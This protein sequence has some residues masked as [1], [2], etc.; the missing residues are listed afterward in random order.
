MQGV[1][2][3]AVEE[4]AVGRLS[5]WWDSASPVAGIPLSDDEEGSRS[6]LDKEDASSISTEPHLKTGWP[7]DLVVIRERGTFSLVSVCKVAW[8]LCHGGILPFFCVLITLMRSCIGSMMS[9]S[10]A[11]LGSR[12]G[13]VNLHRPVRA[14]YIDEGIRREGG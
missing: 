14:I 7:S 11:R 10:E 8:F 5:D 6:V 2:I 12:S 1:E 13:Q 9:Q 3:L 4:L